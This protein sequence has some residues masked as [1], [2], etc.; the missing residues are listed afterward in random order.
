M[1]AQYEDDTPECTA[2]FRQQR[3]NTVQETRYWFE[4]AKTKAYEL[5]RRLRSLS[6]AQG[7]GWRPIESAPKDL[8]DVLLWN[9]EEIVIG[10]YRIDAKSFDSADAGWLKGITHWKP[11]PAPPTTAPDEGKEG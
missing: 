11:L 3:H 5:E 6:P 10:F 4:Q 9:G 2:L 8:E 1:S 7:D